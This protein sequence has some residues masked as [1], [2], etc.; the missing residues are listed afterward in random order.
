MGIPVQCFSQLIH[1]L[2]PDVPA[3]LEFV[4]LFIY[5]LPTKRVC[6]LDFM[7]VSAS[8]SVSCGLRISCYGCLSLGVLLTEWCSVVN[9][10]W[11]VPQISWALAMAANSFGLP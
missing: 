10:E 3:I 7:S 4:Y 11:W 5:L 8:L 9:S 1:L 2:I 6:F